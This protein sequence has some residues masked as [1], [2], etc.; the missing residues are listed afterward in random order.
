MITPRN[1][2]DVAQFHTG[3]SPLS[4]TEQALGRL[5]VALVVVADLS[6]DVGIAVVVNVVGRIT[7]CLCM[8]IPCSLCTSVR[9]GGGSETQE[10]T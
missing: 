3:A 1:A 10:S 9:L 5:E 6:N 8:T 7:K 4:R 2:C